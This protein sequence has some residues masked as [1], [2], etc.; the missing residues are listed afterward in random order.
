MIC[1]LLLALVV[2]APT[3][4]DQFANC[5]SN[6]DIRHCEGAR[7]VY[8]L[9]R[10]P[11]LPPA[12]E[13]ETHVDVRYD[14]RRALLLFGVT[15][16][17]LAYD[18][19][20]TIDFLGAQPSYD[21][22]CSTDYHRRYRATNESD[23]DGA[24]DDGDDTTTYA[25]WS[26]APNAKYAGAFTAPH[27]Y[28]T[29]H[30]DRLAYWQPRAHGCSRVLYEA[31]LTPRDCAN[32][33]PPASNVDDSVRRVA[34]SLR[35]TLVRAPDAVIHM[36]RIV[37]FALYTDRVGNRVLL[38]SELPL[39]LDLLVLQR[40]GDGAANEHDDDDD[41]DGGRRLK[42]STKAAPLQRL[43][44]LLEYDARAF[45]ELPPPPALEANGTIVE[46]RWP[47]LETLYSVEHNDNH[48]PLRADSRGTLNNTVRLLGETHASVTVPHGRYVMVF[49][50]GDAN[51][52][53]TAHMAIDFAAR[54]E[55]AVLSLRLPTMAANRTCFQTQVRSRRDARVV[56]AFLL[57]A[58]LCACDETSGGCRTLYNAAD[59]ALYATAFGVVVRKAALVPGAV[60]LCFD[61]A[62]ISYDAHNEFF[63]ASVHFIAT[64]VATGET[65][66]L[67]A[68]SMP[69][70][71]DAIDLDEVADPQLNYASF[72]LDPPPPSSA[73]ARG[74]DSNQS[75]RKRS[76][77]SYDDDEDSDDD[78]GA[79]D[80]ADIFIV[81]LS[82]SGLWLAVACVGL[83]VL[84][85]VGL[86]CCVRRRTYDHL[87]H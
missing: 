4:A 73:V 57:S 87:G 76:V 2:V 9:S 72:V 59:E 32:F 43:E 40:D 7:D 85:A 47:R 14:E 10:T 60:D 18:V 45:P 24:D 17:Y 30:V 61:T 70:L 13:L 68:S 66:T 67:T 37:H 41:D 5:G 23:A 44:V 79:D 80:D 55:F 33:A 49:A 8:A 77:A 39:D 36:Q 6:A 15:V 46:S 84:I 35:I 58:S 26:H 48:F 27:N 74:G 29:Y 34:G 78:D 19:H 63:S 83:L 22:R 31:A 82:R 11:Q 50:R 52:T 62:S 12:A 20:Y 65:R 21:D 54:D 16:P 86:T 69:D 3:A 38:Q 56:R 25:R 53:E 71:F 75:K 64:A 51:A 81:P 28:T 42:T 1:L